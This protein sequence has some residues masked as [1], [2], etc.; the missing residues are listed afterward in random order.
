MKNE[1]DYDLPNYL[2]FVILKAVREL[3]EIQPDHMFVTAIET[4]LESIGLQDKPQQM[5]LEL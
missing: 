4:A 2:V 3:A 1:L 5:E